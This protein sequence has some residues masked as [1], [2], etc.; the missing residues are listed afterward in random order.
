MS[1]RIDP[2]DRRLL[3]GAGVVFV[4]LIAGV[5]FLGGDPGEKGDA[6]S[7]YSTASGGAKAAYL[8]MEQSGYQVRRWERSLVDLPKTAGTTLILADP[9]EA[10]TREERESLK[11]FLSEGGRIIA[12]GMFSGTFLPENE[13]V[14]DMLLGMTSKKAS[15]VSP[16]AITRAAP[17]ITIAP[18]ARWPSYSPA[19]SLYGDGDEIVV[20]KYP[21]GRGEVLWW[22]AATPLTNAGLKEP[23]NLE[24]LLASVGDTKAPILW[25]EYVHGYR[26]TL[27]SAVVHSP[28]K[29]IL[30]QVAL[31]GLA[32]VATFSRRS[33]PISA[34]VTDV[35]LSPLEFVQTLGG[36][37]ENAGTASVA[38]D[39]CFQRFRYW[40][41]RRLGVA[42]NISINDLE[43]AV[44][45]RWAPK[46]EH[47]AAILRR[48]ESAKGDP[49]L[50]EAEALHLVQEL[51]E[52]A[53]R[54][55]LFEG[56]RKE[57]GE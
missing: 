15:A 51:D 53:S 21:Y 34:P 13:S 48:C 30:L 5:V 14:P 45:D 25:D 55:K 35:R 52:Y 12:T 23:G 29:W 10:P 16:S 20:V 39:I 43:S 28:V 7:S 50:G 9:L 33:G 46:N 1:L 44:R 3:L 47:F 37:Y 19:Y 18:Q 57:K 56:R 41:T 22:A 11:T 2:R 26:E 42:G 54:W 31:L 8:L 36:L 17:E 4:L 27:G 40:L 32:V 6:P 38:V 49:Y 24:F